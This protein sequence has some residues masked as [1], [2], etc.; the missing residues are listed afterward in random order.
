MDLTVN[1]VETRSHTSIEPDERCLGHSVA[2]VAP[3]GLGDRIESVKSSADTQR[4][5]QLES[6]RSPI[7]PPVL[8][9]MTLA[10]KIR[11]AT[12]VIAEQ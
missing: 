5:A 11:I 9:V 12:A 1:W 6:V 3:S 7:E 8:V 2:R 10:F 4:L